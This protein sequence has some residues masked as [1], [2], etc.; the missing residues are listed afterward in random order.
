MPKPRSDNYNPTIDLLR[1]ISIIAVIAIHTT[2]KTI[3]SVG[4]DLR[5]VPGTLFLNQ[6]VRF[7][8]PLFFLISGFVLEI[9]SPPD[10][11]FWSYLKKR[12]GRIFIP[13][14]V[15]SLIYYFFIYPGNTLSFPHILLIGGASYQLYFIPSLLIFYLIFPLLHRYYRAISNA[16][17]LILLGFIQLFFLYHDYY[18]Q[19][20]PIVYP[21][22]I[23]LLN[24]YVFILG[25][26]ASHY[27]SLLQKIF[28]DYKYM[29]LAITGVLIAYVSYEGYSRYYATG[30]YLAFY[31][32]WRPS[33][34]F[35]TLFLSS[36]LY[37]FFSRISLPQSLI[38][39]L[40][41]LSFFVFFVHVI[42]LE[43]V[44]K[45][46]PPSLLFTPVLLVIITT[47]SF[48]IA[49]LCHKLPFLSKLTG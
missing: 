44:W 40:S 21:L 36:A 30:N 32:Q 10:I 28:R 9:S 46:F 6:T 5:L 7:A 33:I 27:Q 49:Y 12:L 26:V 11:N 42:V 45:Y 38:K 13:Y 20:Y 37:Y 29:L 16:W 34:F 19:S 48:I 17:V 41:S 4:G 43:L 18:L 25:I 22:N 35:Y 14:L 31:S 1:L 47:I 3:Q 2:T 8:V 24:F 23:A 39:V 15:W